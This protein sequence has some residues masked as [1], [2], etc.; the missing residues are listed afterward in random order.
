MA[1]WSIDSPERS[2]MSRYA[3]LNGPLNANVMSSSMR[4]EPSFATWTATF[5]WGRSN[6]L[7]SATP[8]RVSAA[9][10]V[11]ARARALRARATGGAARAF[12]GLGGRSGRCRGRRRRA[13]GWGEVDAR[14]A[15]LRLVRLEELACREPERAGDRDAGEGLDRVVVGQHGVVVDLPGDRDPV[16][17]LGKLALQL[18]EVLVGLQLRVRLGDRE[19]PAER[20]AQDPLGLGRLGGRTCALRRGAR[21]GDRLE[22]AALVRRVALDGLDEVRDQ[23]VPTLE[24]DLDLGP[25]V[26]DPVPQPDESVVEDDQCQQHQ[27][28]HHDDHDDCDHD[29]ATLAT[30]GR[31]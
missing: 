22:R 18:P 1:I 16:L 8:A 14:G 3:P 26:L 23:V 21:L 24:L 11:A 7:A 9:T 6:D 13:C 25:R 20:L 31:R 19:Q 10:A 4:S 28:E 17:G 12:G 2:G 27:H 29:A 5:A 15:A 30:Y